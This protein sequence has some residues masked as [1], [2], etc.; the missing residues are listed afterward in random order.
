MHVNQMPLLPEPPG[1]ARYTPRHK[2]LPLRERPAE[3]VAS[4]PNAC[5]TAEL[6]A[7]LFGGPLPIETADGLLAH[8]QGRL[9]D[10]HQA[11]AQEIA[12]LPGIGA[13]NAAR[14]KAAL[15]LGLRLT[16]SASRNGPPSTAR[17]MPPGWCCTRWA[18]WSRST[19]GSSCSTPAIASWMWWRSTAAA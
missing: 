9:S 17:P 10:L 13:Q 11:P 16:Q 4:S 3:R 12:G 8:Y 15:E 18:C 14:L 7:A 2:L 5:T 19:C 6:L 1:E